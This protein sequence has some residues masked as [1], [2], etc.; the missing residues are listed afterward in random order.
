MYA[1]LF[2]SV[3]LGH[4]QSH[5]AHR[6]ASRFFVPSKTT[7][8]FFRW[9]FF[10]PTAAS[11]SLPLVSG[12]VLSGNR[13]HALRRVYFV[14]VFDLTP[15]CSRRKEEYDLCLHGPFLCACCHGRMLSIPFKKTDDSIDLGG[16]LRRYLMKEFS[17]VCDTRL[18]R[19][20]YVTTTATAVWRL[21][22]GVWCVIISTAAVGR[23]VTVPPKH[24]LS[25]A[26]RA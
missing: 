18:S 5:S 4:T 22:C 6:T 12:S 24:S 11:A 16:P 14:C 9:F 21:V 19:Q 25:F 15:F 7:V 13:V 1:D 2:L 10:G 17:K 20:F 3:P 8:N 23:R 26:A